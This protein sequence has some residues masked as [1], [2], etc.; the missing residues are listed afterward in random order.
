MIY[1]LVKTL[2]I[3]LNYYVL[4]Y[5]NKQSGGRNRKFGKK[6][7]AGLIGRLV[8]MDEGKVPKGL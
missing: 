8:L 7:N 2:Q 6:E 1:I 4:N 3:V 5:I